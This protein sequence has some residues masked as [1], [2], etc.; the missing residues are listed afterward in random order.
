MVV[1]AQFE[2]LAPHALACTPRHTPHI[3]VDIDICICTEHVQHVANTLVHTRRRR[4]Q[5][6]TDGDDEPRHD[7]RLQ[8]AP[9]PAPPKPPTYPRMNSDDS[10][11]TTC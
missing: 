5:I 8:A 3:Y 7:G 6:G 1:F 10:Q 4:M 11:R 9:R 2:H